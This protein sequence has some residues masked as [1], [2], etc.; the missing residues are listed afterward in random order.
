M[1][2]NPLKRLGTSGQ[3]IWLDYIRR[4]RIAGGELRRVIESLEVNPHLDQAGG[5]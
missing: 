3:S 2:D 5:Q 4:D 1:Q